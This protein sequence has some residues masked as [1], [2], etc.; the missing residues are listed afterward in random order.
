MPKLMSSGIGICDTVAVS[1]FVLFTSCD[2]V[3]V[4]E[5]GVMLIFFPN[6]LG[7]AVFNEIIPILFRLKL[8]LLIDVTTL[9][10]D[11]C[12]DDSCNC[13]GCG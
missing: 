3:S 7:L 4:D 5:A 12:D 8:M 6:V 1:K 11:G 13:V 2:R 10:G 9:L